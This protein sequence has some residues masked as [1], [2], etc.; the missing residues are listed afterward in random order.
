MKSFGWC[1]VL[2]SGLLGSASVAHAQYDDDSY[3]SPPEDGW[4]G[5][6]DVLPGLR[7]GIGPQFATSPNSTMLTGQF[8]VAADLRFEENLGAS[9]ELGYSGERRGRLAG[10]HL[11]FGGAVRFGT[12][13]GL[14]PLVHGMIGRTHGEPLV[15]T[16]R[17]GGLRIGGRL[18]I[19]RMAGVDIQYEYRA[20]HRSDSESGFRVVLWLDALFVLK[21]VG[22][23]D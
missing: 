3:D 1:V 12:I 18:D 11:V 4:M 6:E 14:S 10:R 21:V 15:P 8:L 5:T 17:S 19:A 9:F 13:V 7:L 16:R 23:A 22:F 20:I 2:V